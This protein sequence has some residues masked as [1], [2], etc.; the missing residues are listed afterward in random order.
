MKNKKNI[1]GLIT[2]FGTSD[3]Y[4]A[5]TKAALL[6][7]AQVRCEV[8]D[9]THDIAPQN[10]L[11]AAYFVDIS[12]DY[13]P[14]GS[15]IA[16]VVDPGVGT[17]R[18]IIFAESKGRYFLAPDNG[19][20]TPVL[21]EVDSIQYVRQEGF[22]VKG[23]TF[24]GRDIFAPFAGMFFSALR[25]GEKQYKEF[26]KRY[27]KGQK[28]EKPIINNSFYSKAHQKTIEGRIL[29]IDRFG[30]V[31]SNIPKK[32]LDKREIESIQIKNT[33]LNVLKNTF[34]DVKIGQ[35]LAYVGSSGYLEFASRNG[36]FAEV[37][38]IS[39]DEIVYVIFK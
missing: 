24:H 32:C 5:L 9:I 28:H 35:E 12:K 21:P 23:N 18:D 3:G 13:F 15:L 30:N 14:P 37:N 29:H 19:I 36:N 22:P 26:R 11:Q 20:L 8:I 27:I 31:I 33:F 4:C 7:S 34:S 25:Q 6:S 10:L 17:N 16:A 38:N 1:I 39:Y 2:D